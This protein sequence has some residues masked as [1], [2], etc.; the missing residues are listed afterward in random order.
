MGRFLPDGDRP[1]KPNDWHS[2]PRQGRLARVMYPNLAEPQYQRELKALI[3]SPIDQNS[4]AH[5]RNPR[6][7]MRQG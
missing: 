6:D 2:I 5:W 7:M 3:P 4:C 1:A